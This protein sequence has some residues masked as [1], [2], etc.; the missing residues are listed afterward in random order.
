MKNY[1][2]CIGN[3]NPIK[4]NAQI[5]IFSAVVLDRR[6]VKLCVHSFAHHRTEHD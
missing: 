2:N 6:K 3:S 1:T 4:H 5:T